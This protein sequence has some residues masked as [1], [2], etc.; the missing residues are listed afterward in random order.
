MEKSIELKE[1]IKSQFVSS[2]TYMSVVR[3]GV[4]YIYEPPEVITLGSGAGTAELIGIYARGE[5]YFLSD[6]YRHAGK[7]FLRE[8]TAFEELY[9]T[10]FDRQLKRYSAKKPIGGKVS[11][12]TEKRL[13]EFRERELERVALDIIF[14]NVGLA[15]KPIDHSYFEPLFFRYLL[16]GS[17]SLEDA[18]RADINEHADE[19]NFALLSEDAAYKR[20]A[21]L[22]QNTKI[23]DRI[24]I[25]AK[26]RQSE[27]TEFF[28]SVGFDDTIIKGI[29]AD[30]ELLLRLIKHNDTFTYK[31]RLIVC[32]DDIIKISHGEQVFYNAT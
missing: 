4:R 24:S 15:D 25:Y 27:F 6:R 32:F 26:I 21:E 31:G 13:D 12:L 29:A 2:D 3:D 8:L 5:F 19:L 28:L 1:Y 16:L 11:L 20:V 9:N 22:L 14:G 23:V 17:K 18:V 30:K 10:A 7:D